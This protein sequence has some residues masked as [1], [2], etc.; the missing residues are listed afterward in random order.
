MFGVPVKD[1]Y[2]HQRLKDLRINSFSNSSGMFQQY[3]MVALHCF[4]PLH[5]IAAALPHALLLAVF[6]EQLFWY[7]L[8]KKCA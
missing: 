3:V 5:C 6:S 7:Y 8:L 4:L 1:M 2:V